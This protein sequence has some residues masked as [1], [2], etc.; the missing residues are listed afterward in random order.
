[1]GRM[2]ERW[3]HQPIESQNLRNG[4]GIDVRG[5][6]SG[7]RGGRGVGLRAVGLARAAAVAEAS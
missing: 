3:L 6:Q 1:M 7:P 2:F 5:S 4:A